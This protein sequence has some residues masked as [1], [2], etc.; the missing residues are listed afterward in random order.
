[1]TAK[2]VGAQAHGSPPTG[3]ATVPQGSSEDTARVGW[4]NKQLLRTFPTDL[5]EAWFQKLPSG[6]ARILLVCQEGEWGTGHVENNL[7]DFTPA[8][9]GWSIPRSCR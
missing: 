7:P 1:M 5:K 9:Q 8:P 4:R 6:L 3:Q 2:A